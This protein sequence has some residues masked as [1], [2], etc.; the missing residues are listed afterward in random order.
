[1]K[2]KDFLELKHFQV[3][4]GQALVPSTPE[5]IEWLEMLNHNSV[6][7]FKIVESRDLK[8]HKAYFGLLSFIYDRLNKA[9]KNSI[10]KEK[11]YEFLK[12][13]SNEYT[14]I[15]K[16]KDGR[17]FI[18][19]KS[20]SFSSMNQTKFKEY[21]NNQLSIIYEEL[22]IPM[23]QDYLMDEVSNEFEKFLDKLI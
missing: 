12:M 17:E 10:P 3:H 20:I 1:M 2:T 18:E 11:F 8:F 5:S 15:F 9:F 13:L 6:V 14:V 19:W 21:V 4:K 23:E 16:F 7:N 22:L